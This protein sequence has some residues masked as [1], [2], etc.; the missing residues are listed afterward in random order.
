MAYLVYVCCLLNR[1]EG[2]CIKLLII[3]ITNYQRLDTS[4]RNLFSLQ[5]GG[6]KVQH[7]MASLV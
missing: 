6:L 2:A 4:E 5:F 7:L 1:K 3:A